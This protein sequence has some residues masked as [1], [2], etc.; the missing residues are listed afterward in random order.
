MFIFAERSWRKRAPSTAKF[1][2]PS[3]FQSHGLHAGQSEVQWCEITALACASWGLHVDQ[4]A[5]L[6]CRFLVS[7][8]AQ[9][10]FTLGSADQ[11]VEWGDV[12]AV[13]V[14]DLKL[15]VLSSWWDEWDLFVLR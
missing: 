8:V 4:H 9:H 15:A 1:S 14:G 7:D 3:P 6:L 2:A 11:P 12:V 13:R 10:D 5:A